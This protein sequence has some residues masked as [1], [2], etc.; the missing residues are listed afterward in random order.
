MS[1]LQAL[2]YNLL[3]SLFTFTFIFLIA[4]FFLGWNVIKPRKKD[5]ILFS[6]IVL[7]IIFS[8]LTGAF[9]ILQDFLKSLFIY[10]K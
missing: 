6:F 8:D 2:V 9:F 3:A 1:L 10:L 4:K 7:S 5:Y